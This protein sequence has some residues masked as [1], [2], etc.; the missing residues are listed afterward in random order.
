MDENYYKILGRENVSD[1]THEVWIDCKML[2]MC[3]I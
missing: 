2:K 3:I 1:T